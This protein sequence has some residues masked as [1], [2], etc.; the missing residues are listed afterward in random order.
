MRRFSLF[1]LLAAVATSGCKK[2]SPSTSPPNSNAV[3]SAPVE[4]NTGPTLIPEHGG[5]VA[6]SAGLTTEIVTQADG[7]ILAYVRGPQGPVEGASVQVTVRNPDGSSRPIAV[8]WDAQAGAYVGYVWG[9]PPGRKTIEVSVAPADNAPPQT[10]SSEVNVTAVATPPPPRHGGTVEIIGQYAVEIVPDRSGDVAFFVMDLQGNPIPSSDVEL[11]RVTVHTTGNA[12]AGAGS[13]V[14]NPQRVGDHFVVHAG[15]DVLA[16]SSAVSLGVDLGVRGRIFTHATVPNAVVVTTTPA[17][18]NAPRTAVVSVTN[19]VGAQGVAVRVSDDD[20]HDDD[21]DDD[22]P[23]RSAAVV[24]RTPGV[25]A[26]VGASAATAVAVQPPAA[27]AVVVGPRA[28]AVVV[29]TP[30][31]VPS[32]GVRVQ[33]NAPAPPPP[34][35]PPPPPAA[36]AQINV[37]TGGGVRIQLGGSIH[38]N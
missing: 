1:V 35:P 32:A 4:T 12:R 37:Q 3:P 17:T 28:P 38:I 2:G 21:D 33:V 14:I 8:A 7:K 23:S 9:V 25:H 30:A 27:R 15:P 16:G 19:N 26:T 22:K 34:P 24:V 13:R 18:G 6:A 5:V 10:V 36:P 11:P 20:D 31:A 29:S